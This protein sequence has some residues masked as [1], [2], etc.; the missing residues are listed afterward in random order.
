MPGAAASIRAD[1]VAP[2]TPVGFVVVPRYERGATTAPTPLRRAEVVQQLADNAFNFRR[3]GACGLRL[4]AGVV[5]AAGCYRLCVGDLDE[6]CDALRSL[7][8]R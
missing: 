2:P 3:L 4:L 6:A 8:R 7:E 5:A 1:A